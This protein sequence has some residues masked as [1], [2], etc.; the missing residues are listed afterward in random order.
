MIAKLLYCH[1]WSCAR[2]APYRKEI[3]ALYLL[4]RIEGVEKLYLQWI[5]DEEW[6]ELES[7]RR[8]HRRGGENYVALRTNWENGYDVISTKP[9]STRSLKVDSRE[10]ESEDRELLIVDVIKRL[11]KPLFKRERL[12][13]SSA[14]WSVSQAMLEAKGF[15]QLEGERKN[16]KEFLGIGP[17]PKKAAEKLRPLGYFVQLTDPDHLLGLL[18]NPGEVRQ[19]TSIY[20]GAEI[21]VKSEVDLQRLLMT[22]GVK[23]HKKYGV[24]GQDKALR[25]AS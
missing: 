19:E 11:R 12:V 17:S 18:T 25:R 10:L 16:T 1:S 6:K 13:K 15:D 8:N 21:L 20:W 7:A 5:S 9:L 22:L 24:D 14:D 2:C 3:Y 4:R 23:K